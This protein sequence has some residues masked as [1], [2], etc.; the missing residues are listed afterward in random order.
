MQKR[1]TDFITY[2]SGLGENDG[3]EADQIVDEEAEVAGATREQLKELREQTKDIFKNLYWT[4]IISV[5]TYDPDDQK[6]WPI[7]PDLSDEH[8]ILF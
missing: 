1:I 4:R 2:V 6:S 8:D 7:A 5:Q 3:E